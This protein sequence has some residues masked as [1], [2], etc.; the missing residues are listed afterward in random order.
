MSEVFSLQGLKDTIAVNDIREFQFP[1]KQTMAAWLAQTGQGDITVADLPDFNGEIRFTSEEWVALIAKIERQT[2]AE[3]KNI[4]RQTILSKTQYRTADLRSDVDS[5]EAEKQ[6]IKE[7]LTD[8]SP[9]KIESSLVLIEMLLWF[10]PEQHRVLLAGYAGSLILDT[11]EKHNQRIILGADN[12][13]EVVPFNKSRITPELQQNNIDLA[14]RMNALVRGG[15]LDTNILRTG[16]LYRA[17]SFATYSDS[18]RDVNGHVL[19][20]EDAQN[21]EKYLEYLQTKKDSG[22]SLSPAEETVM[23]SDGSIRQYPLMVPA[24]EQFQNFGTLTHEVQQQ[25]APTDT[26]KGST[27]EKSGGKTP[28]GGA[29]SAVGAWIGKLGGAIGKLA[30]TGFGGGIKTLGEVLSSATKE[31]G[32][33]GAAVVIWGLI[34]SICKLGLWRTLGAVFSIGIITEADEAAKIVGLDGTWKKAKSTGEKSTKSVEEKTTIASVPEKTKNT[35]DMNQNYTNFLTSVAG[36]PVDKIPE[37]KEILAKFDNIKYSEA[38][39]FIRE[40]KTNDSIVAILWDTKSP[41]YKVRKE[42]LKRYIIG[43]TTQDAKKN[44]LGEVM[45]N[46]IRKKPQYAN[47]TMKEVTEYIFDLKKRADE[48]STVAEHLAQQATSPED[49]VALRESAS[50]ARE[51]AEKGDVEWVYF[52]SSLVEWAKENWVILIEWAAFASLYRIIKGWFKET[53][54]KYWMRKGIKWGWK[55]LQEWTRKVKWWWNEKTVDTHYAKEN[56]T[57]S[58]STKAP[59]AKKSPE[60]PKASGAPDIDRSILK[61]KWLTVAEKATLESVIQKTEELSILEEK[62]GAASSKWEQFGILRKK[63]LLGREIQETLVA[64]TALVEKLK[65]AWAGWNKV[66]LELATFAENASKMKLGTLIPKILK[67]FKKI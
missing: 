63:V 41:E 67:I 47:W 18:L 49:A 12:T 38:E 65:T 15:K 14:L 8:L 1:D 17:E 22:L 6:K 36:L 7:A 43:L 52:Y 2:T 40:G 58:D 31:G 27:W 26:Q 30:A 39:D 33:W 45:D 54:K 53:D 11:F 46:N 60:A 42:V 24:I 20:P 62:L 59:E 51:A 16:M 25:I 48:V 44:G 19:N 61:T 21:P 57:K 56:Q 37:S 4:I 29:P 9:R 10:V 50:G 5:M 66:A 13:V 55:K 23:A 35:P 32:A 64:N 34:A 28:D 3:K